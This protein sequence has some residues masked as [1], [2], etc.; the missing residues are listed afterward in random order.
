[1]TPSAAP[2]PPRP[3]DPNPNRL[4]KIGYVSA[5]YRTHTVAGFIEALLAKHDRTKF[6][7]TA[8]PSVGRGDET[9]SKN[10]PTP[11]GP[12]WACR[13]IRPPG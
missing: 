5:D 13:T 9:T 10:W 3:A 11:G 2:A 6:H 8:Y 7:V 4:L 12:S 1:M